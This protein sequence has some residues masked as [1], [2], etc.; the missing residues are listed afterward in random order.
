MASM[1][2]NR[3]KE[4]QLRDKEKLLKVISSLY[5]N[6]NL[7]LSEQFRACLLQTATLLNNDEDISLISSKLAPFIQTELLNNENQKELLELYDLVKNYRKKY[8]GIMDSVFTIF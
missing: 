5:N 1:L 3:K 6:K 4:N 2:N 7:T 8:L